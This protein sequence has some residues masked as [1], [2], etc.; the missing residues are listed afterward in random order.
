MKNLII[1]IYGDVQG[2]NFRFEAKLTA[3]KL[4]VKG[5][6]RN[7]ADGSV[8]IEA[9]GEEKDTGEIFGMVPQRTGACQRGK[10][11]KRVR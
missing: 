2:V 10:I 9:E 8:Y 11:R 4:G 7:E 3:D 6:V 5:F 1:K